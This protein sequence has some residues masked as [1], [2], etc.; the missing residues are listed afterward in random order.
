MNGEKIFYIVIGR[1]RSG[2]WDTEIA[3]RE[4]E[5]A[6][7][8]YA[9]NRAEA[10]SGIR[11]YVTKAQEYFEATGVA[12]TILLQSQEDTDGKEG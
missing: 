4:S 9:E 3:T 1:H 7:C 6:A 10:N 2:S 11:Y 8:V 5:A 12:S